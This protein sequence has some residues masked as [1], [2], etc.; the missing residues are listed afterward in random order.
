MPR[1]LVLLVLSVLLVPTLDVAQGTANKY[2]HPGTIV[3]AYSRK[4]IMA[5]AYAYASQSPNSGQG[6]P[7]YSSLLDA[8]KS[9]P[10][11]GNFAFHIDPQ[12]SSYLAAYCEQ[13]YA[14]RTE[15]ANDNSVDKVRVQPDPI[16]L[17]PTSHS[18]VSA[19]DV[20]IAAIGTDLDGLHANLWYYAQANPEGFAEALRSPSF[21]EEDRSVIDAVVRNPKPFFPQGLRLEEGPRPRSIENPNVAFGAMVN[22]LN[23]VRSDLVY[24]ERADRAGYS[25]ALRSTFSSSERDTIEA[26]RTR[27]QPFG[28]PSALSVNKNRD[29]NTVPEAIDV[30]TETVAT[31]ARQGAESL[32]EGIRTD[33]VRAEFTGTGGSSGDSVKVRVAKGPKA[34]PGPQDYTVPPGSQLA[35]SDASAQSMTILSVAG[36]AAGKNSYKPTSVITVPA[37]GTATYVLKAFCAEFHKENPSTST[38]FTLKE[39]DPGLAC[40]A[41]NGK[42][43][44]VPAYQAAVWMY[45]DNATFSEVNE[46]FAVST[47]EW[48]SGEP[49]FRRCRPANP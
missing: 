29:V 36:E 21:S 25:G 20:A 23:R 38:H 49:V 39:P 17:Y 30:P 27:P 11:N 31:Q 2:V 6:C 15:T 19:S 43:L 40:I 9:S 28:H 44:S 8:Q 13:G 3:D 1:G 46:K 12:V 32:L 35:S 18:G 10:V 24:Y 37:K 48:S 33:A 5:E 42:D 47:Q 41:R 16:K 34:A 7:T 22:D 26:I 14:P 45:T 4:G